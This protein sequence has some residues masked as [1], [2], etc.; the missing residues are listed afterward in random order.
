M[1]CVN[2]GIFCPY[3]YAFIMMM[4]LLITESPAAE[5][6]NTD[7]RVIVISEE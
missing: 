4:L 1:S 6:K 5:P 3:P 7:P 2:P